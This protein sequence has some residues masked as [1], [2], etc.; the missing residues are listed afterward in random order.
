[1][2]TPPTLDR[3]E[4]A[5]LEELRAH[6]AARPAPAVVPEPP[7]R[8]RRRWVAGL[9][10]AAAA[11]T[12]YVA[13][14]P[15]GPAVSPA[16]A[17][18]ENADGDVVVTVHRL[19][20]SEGLERALR[21]HGIEATVDFDADPDPHSHEFRGPAAE[22]GDDGAPPPGGTVERQ[23]RGQGRPH[24]SRDGD[25][26]GFVTDGGPDGAPE[27]D[28]CGPVGDGLP[29][30]LAHERDGWELRIPAESPLQ[31]RPVW[32]TT[33]GDGTLG[34]FYEGS[35]PGMYCGVMSGGTGPGTR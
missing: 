1:M 25:T 6:V 16:Y 23:E 2:N 19:E 21:A 31:D 14:S 10:A 15:G 28:G 29:A 24:L 34:V 30:T 5:L 8:H 20:D 11:A 26:D 33:K 4:T 12:A 35:R 22:P 27:A 18:S 13:V 32:I 9:A 7:R 17:V 3:F